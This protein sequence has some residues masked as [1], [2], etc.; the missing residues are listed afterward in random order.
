MD[1]PKKRQENK[2]AAIFCSGNPHRI[3]FSQTKNK[4]TINNVYITLSA[5]YPHSLI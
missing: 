5:Q 2:M 4:R 3:S 1:K